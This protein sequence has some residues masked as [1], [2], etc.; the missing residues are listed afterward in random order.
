MFCL[1]NVQFC[2][3]LKTFF[4]VFSMLGVNM[5]GLKV[6][7]FGRTYRTGVALDQDMR[8]LIIDRIL[9]EGGD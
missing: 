9:Q 3:N 4:Q 5:D 8:T 7:R 2:Q 6:D 1:R